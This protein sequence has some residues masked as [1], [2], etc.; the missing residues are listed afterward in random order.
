MTSIPL[1]PLS[2]PLFPS[3]VLSLRI[4][5]VRYLDMIKKCI[6]DQSEFGVVALLSGSEVRTPEGREEL[7]Q[8]GTM[9]RIDAWSAPM[10]GLFHVRCVGTT[11]FR[12]LSTEQ[13]KYGLWR[14]Q[15]DPM[16]ADDE[17]GLPVAL[18][19]AANKL[20]GLIA[21]LQKEGLPA[22]QMPIAAPFHLDECGW[23]ADRWSE[24]LPMPLAQ[25][26]QLLALTD[27]VLRLEQVQQYLVDQGLMP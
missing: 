24:V 15:A 11:R 20:G 13:G 3:G 25:K 10:P 22:D 16:A 17:I 21:E 5:E 9:A 23:V 7:A 6:A 14:G 4:F 12:L 27:P 8:V 19:A 2:K 26:L 1:F 18:Q